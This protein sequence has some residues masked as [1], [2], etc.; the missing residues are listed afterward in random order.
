MSEQQ[1]LFADPNATGGA[2]NSTGNGDAGTGD[3]TDPR[4]I[5]IRAMELSMAEMKA[6]M[7]AIISGGAQKQ[8][9]TPQNNN[10]D[11]E[12]DFL[13]DTPFDK[14]INDGATFNKLL[15][16]VY[17]TGRDVGAKKGAE[18]ALKS[19]PGVVN[20]VVAQKVESDAVVTKFYADN[21]DLVDYKAYIGQVAAEVLTK[22][23]GKSLRELTGEI[24]KITRDRLKIP[25][26][27][28][29][30]QSGSPS[31][32]SSSSGARPQGDSKT[33]NAQE[34]QMLEMLK[35]AGK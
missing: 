32:P 1:N 2:P 20:N 16:K 11:E 23:P 15:N 13:K 18:E 19:L 7:D 24:E 35:F 4:D 8:E 31:L 27:G 28:A 14:V 22:N 10:A 29:S 21:A 12:I 3:N 9:P 25:K 34:K 17:K 26:K 6:K 33:L 5:Q 30:A